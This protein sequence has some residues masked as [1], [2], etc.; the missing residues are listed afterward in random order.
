VIRRTHWQTLVALAVGSAAVTYVL[1]RW[2]VD[3]GNVPIPVSP[4][5]AVVLLA[6]AV[7]LFVQGRAVRRFTQGK[8]AGMNPLHAVRVLMFAKASALAAALQFGFFAA[9]AAIA[10]DHPEAPEARAQAISSG[11]AA[12]ACVVLVVVALVVEWF[13]RVP[14]EDQEPGP[15]ERGT[16][17]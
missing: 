7:V 11:A 2:W 4:V 6:V 10:L 5:I 8:R 3:R 13:C 15:G 12:L 9:H 14:P 17:A 1:A 16:P